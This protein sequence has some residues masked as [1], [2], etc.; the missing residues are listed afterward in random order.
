M[1]IA[2][3]IEENFEQGPFLTNKRDYRNMAPKQ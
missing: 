1:E 3:N 2:I